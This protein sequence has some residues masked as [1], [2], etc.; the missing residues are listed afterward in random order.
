MFI[1][2]FAA[3]SILD[4]IMDWLYSMLVGFLSEF[5]AMMNKMGAEL[6]DLPWVEAVVMFFSNL[7]WMLYAVGLV[8]ACL[9]INPG[10]EI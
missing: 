9:N 10:G 3:G 6:F 7:G 4:Q 5:F 1:W 8:V 2:D